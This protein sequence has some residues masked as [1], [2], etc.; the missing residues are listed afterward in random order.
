M[1]AAAAS[2]DEHSLVL[3]WPLQGGILGHLRVVGEKAHQTP[4]VT[5]PDIG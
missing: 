2:W 5:V 3:E 1:V 4:C